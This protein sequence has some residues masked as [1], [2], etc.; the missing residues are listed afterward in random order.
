MQTFERDLSER[1]FN[2]TTIDLELHKPG[3]VTSTGKV[4]PPQVKIKLNNF[5]TYHTQLMKKYGGVKFEPREKAYVGNLWVVMDLLKPKL[6]V[7]SKNI[8]IDKR[9]K[10]VREEW[11]AFIDRRPPKEEDVCYVPPLKGIPPHE[12]FQVT[13]IQNSLKKGNYGIFLKQG[14]GKSY[15]IASVLRYLFKKKEI[16]KVIICTPGTGLLDIKRKLIQF[17]GDT[18]NE[19]NI[20]IINKHNRECLDDPRPVWIMTYSTLRLVQ[21]HYSKGNQTFTNALRSSMHE[22]SLAV[23]MDEGHN[24][25]NHTS[26]QGKAAQTLAEVASYRFISTGTPADKPSKYYAVLKF[27]HPYLVRYLSYSDWIKCVAN[28]GTNFSQFA[29]SDYRPEDLRYF[30]GDGAA[31][32]LTNLQ[33]T[34]CLDLPPHYKKTV[35]IELEEKQRKLYDMF[36]NLQLSMLKANAGALMPRQVLNKFPYL[37]LSL[38]NPEI[39]AQHDTTWYVSEEGDQDQ[40]KL[41]KKLHNQLQKFNFSKDHEKIPYLKELLEEHVEGRGEKAVVWTGHPLT[42]DALA[43]LLDKYNPL[44]IHGQTKEKGL[45]VDE[46]KDKTVQTFMNSDEHQVL[47]A[48]YLV[49]DTA[50]DITEATVQIYFDM[51]YALTNFDQSSKRLH[52]AGQEKPVTSYYLLFANTIDETRFQIVSQKKQL[53]SKALDATLPIEEW[54]KLFEGVVPSSLESSLEEA[55]DLF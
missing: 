20:A 19:R 45:T 1:V 11:G 29:I 10:K 15:I 9:A 28:L 50:L 6:Q 17:A 32:W 40:H 36:M 47:I 7:P 55:Q 5:H 25:S 30:L 23:V 26:Q 34:D 39:L 16:D 27:I 13:T 31:D 46:V 44:V 21:K 12:D 8:F 49:L 18:F 52:R 42:A 22:R 14:T 48:S 37:L 54:R 2:D 51:P 53:D 33:D 41:S 24:I 3:N 35:P 38:D 4:Y 43:P